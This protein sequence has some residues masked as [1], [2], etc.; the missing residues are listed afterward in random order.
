M[1][2]MR[3]LIAMA[4]FGASLSPLAQ[5]QT[6]NVGPREVDAVVRIYTNGPNGPQLGAGFVTECGTVATAY[7]V[8]QGAT[9]V[10]VQGDTGYYAN[11]RLVAMDPDWDLALLLV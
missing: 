11:P 2:L 9:R 3:I 8:I 5:V 1:A 6:A 7:H 4:F 10:S